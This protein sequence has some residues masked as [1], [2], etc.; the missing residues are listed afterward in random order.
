MASKYPAPEDSQPILNLVNGFI[1]SAA[2]RS[3]LTLGL[4]DALSKKQKSAEALAQERKLPPRAT[5]ILLDALVAHTLLEKENDTYKL[6]GLAAMFLVKSSPHF[7]SGTALTLHPVMWEAFEN[8]EESVKY[9]GTV[10][11]AHATT[12]EHDFWQVFSTASASFAKLSSERL[13]G[14]LEAHLPA[15][16]AFRILDVACGTG[17]YGGTLASKYEKARVTFQDQKNVLPQTRKWASELGLDER[18]DYAE[19]DIFHC[20]LESGYDLAILSHIY[21]HFPPADVDRLTEKV[22]AALKP[23]G[24][25][26]VHEFM[27]T[28]GSTHFRECALFSLTMLVWTKGGEAYPLDFY[29]SLFERFGIE[30]IDFNEVDEFPSQILVGRK[31]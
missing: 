23:G 31:K 12:P 22:L 16:E 10:L 17:F 13:A 20:E 8:L 21:H 19:G 24:L 7:L 6:S 29:H 30:K 5:R 15:S 4:F 1:A 14:V 26:A 11:G 18:A 27:A 28:P 3:G 2:L 9:D 25:I